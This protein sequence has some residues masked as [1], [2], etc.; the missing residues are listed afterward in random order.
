MPEDFL[1]FGVGYEPR[2]QFSYA[3]PSTRENSRS[4]SVTTVNPSVLA[5]AA[6]SRSFPPMGMP[7]CSS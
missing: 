3:T 5:W 7:A 1:L 6:I 4:L 2:S